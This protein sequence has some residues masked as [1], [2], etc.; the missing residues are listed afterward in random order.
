MTDEQKAAKLM[1]ET[2]IH[3]LEL[4][5]NSKSKKHIKNY[6]EIDPNCVRCKGTGGITQE[7]QFFKISFSCPTCERK[8][9]DKIK[10]KEIIK[11]GVDK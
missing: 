5:L 11:A 1:I 7:Q 2:L 8:Y 6:F 9:R 4:A 3:E 10:Q